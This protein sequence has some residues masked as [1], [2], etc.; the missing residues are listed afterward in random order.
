MRTNTSPEGINLLNMVTL[1][2]N[3][4]INKDYILQKCSQEQL[5]EFYIGDCIIGGRINSPLRKDDCPSFSLFYN[6]KGDIT[7]YKVKEARHGS[8]VKALKNL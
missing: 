5:Y 4:N 8:L 2:T 7:G 1:N 6:K 3:H